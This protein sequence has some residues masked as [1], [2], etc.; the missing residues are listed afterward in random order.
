VDAGP[1]LAEP[2]AGTLAALRDALTRAGYEQG[3]IRAALGRR[4]PLPH[5]RREVVR[6]RLSEAG[7]L[8]TLIRLFH[9]GESVEA[10]EAVAALAPADPEALL[11]AGFL[12]RAGDGVAARVA[13][14]AAAGLFFAHDHSDPSEPPASWH[15]LL[16]AASHTLAA[17]T[18]RRPA[19]LALDLGTGCGVQALLAARHVEHV[20]A[21]DVSARALCFTR[22][23]AALNDLQNVECRRGDLFEPVGGERFGLIASNPPFV[24]SPDS[25]LVFRD[26]GLPG[27]ELSRRVVRGAQEHLEDGGH[28]TILCNWIR[29]PDGHWAIPPR[30][31]IGEGCDGLLL[32]FTS[33]RP[34]E[35]A[36]TWTDA[37]DRWLAYYREHNVEWISTGAVILRRRPGA[38]RIVAYQATGRPRANAGEQIVRILDAEAVDEASLAAGRFRLVDHE[39]QQEARY[40]D[41]AYT[42]ELTGVSI[43]GSPLNV[44]AEPDAVHA[45]ARLDGL[46]TVNEVIDRTAGETGLDRERIERATL[47]T[48]RRLYERGFLERVG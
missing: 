35:Y 46:L 44:R 8:G 1:Q 9:L 17:L 7:G 28:A 29:P 20:V 10:A 19:R 12:E 36:A 21:T 11:E 18:I 15:V 40:R 39:L 26:S 16:G 34:L 23:N 48:V 32:Q 4:P 41:G 25:E 13:L 22:I 37:F 33:V 30:G 42:I 47:T 27:D 43:S 38:G 14:T 45:L 31:W 5:T 6:R 24:I 3:R 2:D